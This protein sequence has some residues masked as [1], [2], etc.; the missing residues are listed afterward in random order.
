[1]MVSHA[2][3]LL[4]LFF[5][6]CAGNEDNYD[7][8]IVGGGS[9][10]SVLANRLSESGKHSVLLL[11][12]AGAPP[13]AYGGPVLM[14]D[15]YIVQRNLSSNNGLAVR[16]QQPGYSAV[17][18]FS[19]KETGSSP[20]RWLG[21]S[22]LVGLSI[23]L[24]DH[25]EALD[26]WGKGWGWQEMRKQFHKVERLAETCY[27]GDKSCGDYGTAGPFE[28]AKEPAYTH[29]LTMD[30]LAAA[31]AA[32]IQETRDLN[33]RHGAA[34]AVLATAQH[35]DGTKSHAFDAYLR[36]AMGRS[37]L[38]IRHGARADRLILEGDVCKG[39]AYRD[40]AG[41]E[42]RVV[43]ARKEVILSSGY[44][45]S[46]RLLFLSGLGPRRDLEKVGLSVIKDLPA[47][48]KHL[49][50]ARYSPM[51]WSTDR[52]TLSQMMG[53]PIS[54]AGLVP[55]PEAYQ[56]T[57]QE[58]L[59]RFR[60]RR[61]AKAHPHSERPDV[62]VMFTP[63]Y[64]SLK[65]APLQFSLQGEAWPLQT[66]AYTLLVT[67]GETQAKGEVTFT[68]ASPDVSPVVTHEAL[69]D[70]DWELAQE[71][72]EFAM[73]LGNSSALGGKF[74]KNGAGGR[75]AFSA[76][77]DGRGSCRMGVD[78][79]DSVVDHQL[80]V[81]G[82]KG[83]RIVDGSVIPHAS[84]YLALPEVLALAERAAELMLGEGHEHAH[85]HRHEGKSKHARVE[86]HSRKP[87]LE[88]EPGS[89]LS[90]HKAARNDEQGPSPYSISALK[91]SVGA[92]AS[93]MEMIA[94]QAR[95][96]A[97]SME[98]LDVGS[99]DWYQQTFLILFV[100]AAFAGAAVFA[101]ALRHER[102]ESLAYE[103]LIA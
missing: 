82:V 93:L 36:P 18:A 29:P 44:V 76:L 85:H 59:A 62:A 88:E 60:S 92:K 57:V 55:Q 9:A 98:L 52:P 63:I 58:A 7:Y 91:R 49:T 1:M 14:S 79:K 84:P 48:G 68:S 81:H 27:G 66:N 61:A 47:V 13:A 45:Y 21:G 64:Q 19:V 33:T 23:Y 72:V 31:K 67:L 51:S 2:W 25:P 20:A 22:S 38:Q 95:D 17:E 87:E 42:D 32:G 41:S 4:T 37:N 97:E 11:N 15:E 50:S 96:S 89:H 3:T 74:I 99:T 70:E 94:Y 53:A 24:R 5:V 39:V 46:P 10:G 54:P 71:A 43:F 101:K 73:K 6:L 26:A 65:S 28:L 100:V 40:L 83:L 90:K 16:I 56:S 34:A 75:D 102:P 35:S 80:R 103:A 78:T 30:F 86:G 77:Y 8:V 69:T 12:V